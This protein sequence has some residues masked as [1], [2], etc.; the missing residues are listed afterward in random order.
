M[1]RSSFFSRW[2]RWSSSSC[3]HFWRWGWFFN[4]HYFWWSKRLVCI[5]LIFISFSYWDLFIL[6][7]W[8]SKII[9]HN[10]R[11]INLLFLFNMFNLLRWLNCFL[12]SFFLILVYN[13]LISF[14]LFSFNNIINFINIFKTILFL[15]YF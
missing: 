6:K 13:Y 3:I 12:F 9:A 10:N 7:R 1:C 15:L 2:W 11:L 5:L 14:S 4:I 8:C